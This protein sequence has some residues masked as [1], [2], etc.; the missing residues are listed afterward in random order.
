MRYDF[1]ITILSNDR[2]V[3]DQNSNAY[4]EDLVVRQT[5]EEN[6]LKVHKISWSKEYFDWSKTKVTLIRS[7][8]DYHHRAVEW[9]SF[10]SNFSGKN[11]LINHEKLIRWNMD[12]HY[13]GDLEKLGITIPETVFIEEGNQNSLIEHYQN[14][15]WP[16]IILKPCFSATARHTYRVNSNNVKSINATFQRLIQNE[17]LMIQPFLHSIMDEG[18]ISLVIIGGE[19]TH[20]T[21]KRAKPGDFRVQDDFG[22]T[23]DLYQPS[24]DEIEFAKRVV[25]K[26]DPQPA[27]ARVDLVKDN[28]GQ[29]ALIELELIEPELW[30][31]LFPEAAE[32]FASVLMEYL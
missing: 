10:L 4:Q 28:N 7:T 29:L 6:G 11:K 24:M 2:Y 23:A 18:E 12:K 1:D 8:W 30:F 32:V 5:L 17:S 9:N 14:S 25:S 15:G 21:I 3:D 31:R 16:E 20:A 22:G 19:F 13:L 26:C 27:Y